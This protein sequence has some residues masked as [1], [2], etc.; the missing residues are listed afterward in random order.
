MPGK[1]GY[2]EEQKKLDRYLTALGIFVLAH[3]STWIVALNRYTIVQVRVQENNGK[4]I[5]QDKTT[6]PA[7]LG[8]NSSTTIR[9]STFAGAMDSCREHT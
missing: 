2:F 7:N 8:E 3:F 1:K 4:T 5:P 6:M 9:R